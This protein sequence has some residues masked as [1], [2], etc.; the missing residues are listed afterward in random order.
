[1]LKKIIWCLLCM[2][3]T[4]YTQ[5]T[6]IHII[7]AE[8]FYGQLATELGGAE[9][10]VTSIINNPAADPH[11]F[12][13]SPKTLKAL[14]SAQ[15]IIYNGLGYDTWIN[16]WVNANKGNKIIINVSSL[17][18]NPI[19]GNP[20]IWYDPD[21]LLV[22]AQELTK[23]LTTI[24]PSSTKTFIHNLATFTQEHKAVAHKIL[25]LR[26]KYQGIRVTATEPVYGYMARALGLAML[27]TNFQQ[28]IMNDTEPSPRMM[29]DYQALITSGQVKLI[30][31]NSQVTSGVT[32]N[33]KQLAK[34]HSIRLV[35][36]SETMP[37][38]MTIKH[39]YLTTLIATES[40]LMASRAI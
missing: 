38:N 29:A 39:W 16:S 32:E 30:F 19:K 17:I 28:K 23:D 34:L 2:V 24:Q 6:P 37:N 9:V 25:E 4:S 35:A 33:I 10:M 15:I 18:K 21:T 5:A 13:T 27:A 12:A 8:N 22:L 36:I 11:L 1:M 20:H 3:T 7:A 14:S 31:Y 40:A 26:T